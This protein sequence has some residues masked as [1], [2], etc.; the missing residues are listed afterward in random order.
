[1]DVRYQNIKTNISNI[2]IQRAIPQFVNTAVSTVWRT[3]LGVTSPIPQFMNSDSSI[4]FALA[5]G[6]TPGIRTP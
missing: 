2:R 6:T 3:D 4:A 1:M 5:M